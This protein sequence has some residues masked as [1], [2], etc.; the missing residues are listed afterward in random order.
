MRGRDEPTREAARPKP[1]RRLLMADSYDDEFA[2]ILKLLR[3]I[4][5]EVKEARNEIRQIPGQLERH[6][7]RQQ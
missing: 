7:Y 4:L 6:R 1:H 3:E 2:E 5:K